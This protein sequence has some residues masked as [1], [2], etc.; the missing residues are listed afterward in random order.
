MRR[1]DGIARRRRSPEEVRELLDEY[2]RSGLTQQAFADRIGVS[3]SSVFLWLR[4][5]RNATNEKSPDLFPAASRLVPV[6]IRSTDP[7]PFELVTASGVTLRIPPDFDPAALE[8]LL[9]LLVD[10]C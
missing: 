9:P 6:T 8:R 5:A 10:R 1:H 4:K 7:S 3:L 2:E